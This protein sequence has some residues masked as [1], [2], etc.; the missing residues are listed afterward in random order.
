MELAL[1]FFGVA[2]LLVIVLILTRRKSPGPAARAG[3]AAP[4]YRGPYGGRSEVRRNWLVGIGGEV[5]GKTYFIGERTVTIGRGPSNHIQVLDDDASRRHCQLIPQS[6]YLE[7][8]D[9]QSANGTLL[10]GDRIERGRL[11]PEDRLQ[12]G[13][14][15][16]RYAARGNFQRDDASQMKNASGAARSDTVFADD[17]SIGT[18]F[19]A[20]LKQAHGDVEAAAA[21]VGL[22]P[23]ALVKAL[24]ENGIEVPTRHAPAAPAAPAAPTPETAN[25]DTADSAAAP[26]TPAPPADDEPQV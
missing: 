18:I 20:A 8:V 19:A 7:V 6:G 9:L 3:A 26:D 16:F 5:E 4:A 12:I 17:L 14:A 22:T 15:V 11:G 1:V 25:P 13:E 24:R 23:E 21:H 2:L 10:N